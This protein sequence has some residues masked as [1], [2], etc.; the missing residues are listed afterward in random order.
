MADGRVDEIAELLDYR[1][2]AVPIISSPLSHII[3]VLY[4]R[5]KQLLFDS[6]NN[7]ANLSHVRI[8][9]TFSI[10][11][12]MSKYIFFFFHENSWITS[13]FIFKT[14]CVELIKQGQMRAR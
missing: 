2:R 7:V 3:F 5:L 11:E 13:S 9:P 6:I 1:T 8:S 4:L 12:C 14:D 10:V